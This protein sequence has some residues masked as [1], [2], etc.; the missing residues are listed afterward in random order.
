M[1]GAGGP[2]IVT[3]VEQD[4]DDESQPSENERQVQTETAE[5][6]PLELPVP[7]EV[8]AA[9]DANASWS[10]P[11]TPLDVRLVVDRQVD[12]LAHMTVDFDMGN[13]LPEQQKKKPARRN[14]GSAAKSDP[15]PVAGTGAL[16]QLARYKKAPLP[17]YP[18]S[19]KAAGQEGKV[20][21]QIHIDEKG[22]PQRVTIAK[23][24]GV[25]ILDEVSVQWVRKNWSF[26]PAMNNNVPIAS[27][28]RAPLQFTLD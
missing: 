3:L 17:P 11:V 14:A 23:S 26:Y 20:I 24:S 4:T 15:G 21:L 25:P 6:M 7:D 9:T 8:I 18:K 28:A 19:A 16:T 22:N 13:L 27:I 5:A 2:L 12:D 10:W 1:P